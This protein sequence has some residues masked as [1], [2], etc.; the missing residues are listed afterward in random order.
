MLLDQDDFP[1]HQTALPLAH[2]M[3]GH[4]NAYD[5][6]WFNGYNE[7]SF[8]AVALGLY[9]NRGVIDAAFSVLRDG[10]QRSVF[11]GDRLEGRPTAVGPI[12]IEIIEPMRRNRVVVNAPD[13]GI[14][15]DLEFLRRTAPVE[16]PRQSMHDG[17]RIFMDVT[18]ATQMGTWRGWIETPEGR[19]EIEDFMGTKDRSWGVRPIGEPLPGAPSNRVPQLCF[20]WAQVNFAD[21]A[22]HYMSFDDPRGQPLIRSAHQVPLD[23]LGDGQHLEGSI[24]IEPLTATRRAAS[25]TLSIGG[26]STLLTPLYT[27]YMRGAGYSHPQ[28][29]HGRWHGDAFV[30]SELL[31]VASL[32]ALEYSNIHVQQV[33]RAT[34]GDRVGLGVLETLI[35][36][37]YA[38]MGLSSLLDGAA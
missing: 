36:G 3:N 19:L 10:T 17:E 37:P 8:F 4:P 9:P 29:A 23:G 1:L 32:D 34:Q 33:V 18:R 6:F 11:C 24:V 13:H 26:Q 20:N 28:F 12:T 14:R 38:P 27:F 7:E 2:V 5:R 35:I 31:A 16:E 15:A 30:D 22:L 21:G 25:A